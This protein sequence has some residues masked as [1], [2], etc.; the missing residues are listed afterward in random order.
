MKGP[1]QRQLRR[2]A[3]VCYGVEIIVASKDNPSTSRP[4]H[5]PAT[6]ARPSHVRSAGSVPSLK[7]TQFQLNRHARLQARLT[8]DCP[9]ASSGIERCCCGSP[10]GYPGAC[11]RY[12]RTAKGKAGARAGGVHCLRATRALCSLAVIA[13]ASAGEVSCFARFVYLYSLSS[14]LR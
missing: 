2:R 11:A 13:E 3:M 6:P 8:S 7:D 10:N 4:A 9:R 1:V 5:E 14:A 12:S